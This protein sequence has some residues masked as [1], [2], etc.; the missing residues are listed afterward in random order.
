MN[1]KQEIINCFEKK[2]INDNYLYS[3]GNFNSSD[4]VVDKL[5][6]FIS[7]SIDKC[8]EIE[9]ISKSQA[10]KTFNTKDIVYLYKNDL[11]DFNVA[12]KLLYN[13]GLWLLQ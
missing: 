1:K 3:T 8:L 12:R 7:Q 9:K 4:P 13:K 6:T 5:K 2:F 11:I 10:E